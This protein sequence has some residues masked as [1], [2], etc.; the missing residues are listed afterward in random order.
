MPRLDETVLALSLVEVFKA[1]ARAG[2]ARLLEFISP[3]TVAAR[4]GVAAM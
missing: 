4:R 1:T 3:I 2:M